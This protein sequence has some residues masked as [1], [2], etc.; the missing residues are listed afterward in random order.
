MKKKIFFLLRIAVTFIIIFILWWSLKD[1]LNELILNLS[2]V[3]K[4]YLLLGF[5]VYLSH[6]L[7]L[8]ARLRIIF[9]TQSLVLNIKEAF[10]LNLIGFFFNAFL[11]TSVGGDVVKAYYVSEKFSH[12]KVE[13]YAAVFAD[14]A[15]GLMSIISI[16][17]ISLLFVSE[18]IVVKET[19]YLI[20]AVFLV[21]LFFLFFSF[22]KNFAEKF[23]FLLVILRK[24][25]LEQIAKRSYWVF[26]N[27]KNHKKTG[28]LA[29]VISFISQTII[30]VVFFILAKGLNLDLPL[31][32]FF[33][34]V[35]I[36]TIAGMI[37]SLGGTGPREGAFVLLFAPLVGA[38]NAAALALLWL[39]FFLG[40]SLIGGGVYAL[41]GYRRLKIKEIE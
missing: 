38:A 34:F 33:L 24:L 36:I 29:I 15:I 11:P 28:L 32:L 1:N 21:G 23:K 4:F 40:L 31:S 3:D 41:S 19:R 35:P 14:R 18:E 26:N 16:A 22:N 6:T 39:L 7:L 30:I 37:P 27:F 9:F 5:F 20:W 2:S 10:R 12:K 13:S 25:K 8:A 17:L